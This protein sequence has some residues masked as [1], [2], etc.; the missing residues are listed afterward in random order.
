MG[1]VE[2]GQKE[3]PVD[4]T[5]NVPSNDFVPGSRDLCCALDV[6][7]RERPCL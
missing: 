7:I 5:K 6:E 2:A 3:D 4:S 1:D